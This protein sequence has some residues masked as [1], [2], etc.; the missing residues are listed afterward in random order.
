MA[1]TARLGNDPLELVDLCLGALE[2]TELHCMLAIEVEQSTS[3]KGGEEGAIYPL[4]GE[5]AGALVSAVA[6]EFNDA[7]LVG[8][9]SRPRGKETLA[10]E[11]P[12]RR[13]SIHIHSKVGPGRVEMRY[14]EI[15]S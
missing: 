4:L 7:A 12:K 9:E 14:H 15:G 13:L 8:S 11:L 1:S 3:R 5:L 10:N 6:E 2:G